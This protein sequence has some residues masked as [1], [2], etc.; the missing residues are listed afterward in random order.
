MVVRRPPVEAD[1]NSRLAGKECRFDGPRAFSSRQGRPFSRAAASTRT[2]R[3]SDLLRRFW[4]IAEPIPF[5]VRRKRWPRGLIGA[6][7]PV[8]PRNSQRSGSHAYVDFVPHV[9]AIVVVG[10]HRQA[11]VASA[12]TPG[13]NEQTA[14]SS[15]HAPH[16][17]SSVHGRRVIFDLTRRIEPAIQEKRYR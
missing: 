5:L 9:K 2:E 6:I 15:H 8:K 11:L 10:I 14:C 13:I 16:Q 7:H 1:G 17:V 4:F 12:L 3:P